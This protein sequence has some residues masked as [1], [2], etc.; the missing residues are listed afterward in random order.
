MPS[1]RS[2]MCRCRRTSDRPDEPSDRER[3]QTVFARARGSIAAPTAGLHFDR[4]LIDAVQAAG[5]LWTT[6]TLARRLRD[7]QTRADRKRPEDHRVDAERFD[8]PPAT[9]AA[10]AAAH[11]AGRRVLAVGTTTTRALETAAVAR[12]GR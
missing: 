1:T 6:L 4:A 9:A 7:L 8:I 2:D 10:I 3:Y 11:A 5:V 12:P